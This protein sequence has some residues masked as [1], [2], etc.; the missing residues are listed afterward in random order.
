[1]TA[2]IGYRFAAAA[3]IALLASLAA[4]LPGGAQSLDDIYAKAKDEGAR[5]RSMSAARPRRGKPAPRCSKNAI[6]ASKS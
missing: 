4:T 6:P 5:S 3:G 2:I 1:M